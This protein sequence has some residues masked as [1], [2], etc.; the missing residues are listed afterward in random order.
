MLKGIAAAVD[1][2]AAV[3]GGLPQPAR[4]VARAVSQAV[5]QRAV[6]QGVQRVSTT[7]G[8]Q[9]LPA[10]GADPA[11]DLASRVVDTA[12]TKGIRQALAKLGDRPPQP[13]AATGEAEAATPDVTGLRKLSQNL[14]DAAL[15]Q[16]IVQAARR[17]VRFADDPPA[18]VDSAGTTAR[19]V[20]EG[21]AGVSGM[22]GIAQGIVSTVVTEGIQQAVPTA[23]VRGD[24]SPGAAAAPLG[25]ARGVVGGAVAEGITKAVVGQFQRPAPIGLPGPHTRT[26]F[27]D[28][29][30]VA[31]EAVAAALDASRPL[32]VN[33]WRNY[34]QGVVN[35]AVA[36]GVGRAAQRCRS[37][38]PTPDDAPSGAAVDE[39]PAAVS[40]R[41][42]AVGA[43]AAAVACGVARAA[44]Q[45]DR[46]DLPG[47]RA[48]MGRAAPASVAPGVS[49]VAQSLVQRAIV[50][51]LEKAK[52]TH[53][54]G[55]SSV[56]RG[57][58]ADL[59]GRCIDQ[60][61]LQAIPQLRAM[62]VPGPPAPA[63]AR[64]SEL[65]GEESP[66]PEPSMVQPSALVAVV[67]QDPP[68]PV[69]SIADRAAKLGV[70]NL[71]PSSP[72]LPHHPGNW[73]QTPT[74]ASSMADGPLSD[75]N[76]A[77][78]TA[79]D[80]HRKL[81]DSG[82]SSIVL[83]T[84][85]NSPITA[86]SESNG[87]C[88]L[89]QDAF[90]QYTNPKPER[91]KSA[92]PQ[93]TYKDAQAALSAVLLQDA[94]A[95]ASVAA[96]AAPPSTCDP[97]GPAPE[98]TVL[99]E[100]PAVSTPDASEGA[101]AGLEDGA[102]AEAEAVEPPVAEATPPV[103]E[104]PASPAPAEEAAVPAEP[105]T[106]E[107]ESALAADSAPGEGAEAGL[108]DGTAAEAEA[109]EP[110]VEEAPPPATPSRAAPATALPSSVD[111]AI[112]LVQTPEPTALPVE[113]A[114]V[115]PVAAPSAFSLALSPV[116]SP[117]GRVPLGVLH[118]QPWDRRLS[119][120]LG[121]VVRAPHTASIG[122][123]PQY[124]KR[125]SITGSQP[126]SAHRRES[127]VLSPNRR[128]VELEAAGARIATVMPDSS[129]YNL[130]GLHDIL[131]DLLS[132]LTPEPTA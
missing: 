5:V 131:S 45:L 75:V 39:A 55:A 80:P 29:A 112:A 71:A 41:S 108:E 13:P 101:E 126:P 91:C 128:S 88:N 42:V 24:G 95:P 78:A 3:A 36:E 8:A 115:T 51:G 53:A 57:A 111:V 118:A 33:G 16:G 11:P 4:G 127:T 44:M 47:D 113:A 129:L 82:L 34:A 105:P 94:A 84:V 117:D 9:G 23:L 114:A 109:V 64:P 7:Q 62:D 100:E 73:P 85:I 102:A 32:E 123:G 68:L 119:G 69:V 31:A 28:A 25:L 35:A 66:S 65:E 63:L 56:S 19:E 37:R 90:T 92:P 76:S 52:R 40:L 81:E 77:I 1:C 72:T 89:F 103:E 120:S 18:P 17:T 121:P 43:V 86:A 6:A 93:L 124:S 58:I 20:S 50:G 79:A 26:G 130:N 99:R 15:M 104:D 70:V 61:V 22:R 10:K 21:T 125:P 54:A 132:T 110:P 83:Q 59:L 96:E 49:G 106:S 48:P 87:P 74:Q 97:A 46:P 14:V 98:P 2:P 60:G 30:A 116:S 122:H 38:S 107:P 12:V 27:L 67:P